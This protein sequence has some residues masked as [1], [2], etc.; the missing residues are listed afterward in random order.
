MG[1][2]L[3][4]RAHRTHGEL[5]D[6]VV[7]VNETFDDDAAVAD[8]ATGHGVVPGLRHVSR[9]VDLALALAGA[10]HHGLDDAGIPDARVDGGLQL[11]QRVAE[12]VGAGGHAQRLGGQA[13][14]AFAVHREAGGAGRGNHAHHARVFQLLQHG[15]GDGLDLGHHQ[16]GL[17]GLDERLELVGVAH[18]D[19]ARVVRHLLAG[20]VL[21]AVDGDGLDAQ[22]LQ[23]DQHLLAELAGAEQHHAGGGR[24]Q[25]GAEGGHARA[26]K[27]GVENNRSTVSHPGPVSPTGTAAPPG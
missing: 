17:L 6:F 16:R 5:G 14:D 25:G 18:G 27:N 9:A 7:K 8:A 11:G 3:A 2:D 23:G 22:A 26:R 12:L 24:G 1:L 21:V 10:A 13:A 19:G 4:V 15:R 20:G